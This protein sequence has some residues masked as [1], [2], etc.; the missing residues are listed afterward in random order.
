MS[1]SSPPV[2]AGKTGGMP[3]FQAPIQSDAVLAWASF[4]GGAWSV[5]PNGLALATDRNGRPQFTLALLKRPDDLLREGQYAVLDLEL[6]GDYPIEQALALARSQAAT[7]TLN[8]AAIAL[9]F[10]R[11]IPAGPDADLPADLT[12]PTPLGWSAADGARWTHRLDIASAELVKA[13]LEN[14]TLLFGARVEFTVD[15]VAPRIDCQITFQPD[16]LL[17]AILAGGPD[18][19]IAVP[20][21]L[22]ALRKA[23]PITVIGAADPQL[24]QILADRLF[25]A[26]GRLVPA[27]ASADPPWIAFDQAPSDSISWDLAQPQRVPRAFVM[28]LDPLT[29]L[30]G[31][32]S[33]RVD[34]QACKLEYS[35]VSPK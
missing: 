27:P 21:L 18:R 10:A 7:A 22:A 31:V 11:L 2:D 19:R 16:R 4:G 30:Q 15:G 5:L 34:L 26:W 9:G 35:I 23:P 20:D 24:P 12:V 3:D 29:I 33:S 17:A 25:A 6:I 1:S 28:H 14:R 32:G 8:P 13:A